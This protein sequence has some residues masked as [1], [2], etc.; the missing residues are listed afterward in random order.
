MHTAYDDV[1]C[2]L[3][4]SNAS[5]TACGER[6]QLSRGSRRRW[7][8]I[9]LFC[10]IQII[11][12]WQSSA[13]LVRVFFFFFALYSSLRTRSLLPFHCVVAVILVL[14]ADA[15]DEWKQL[16]CTNITQIEL[17]FNGMEFNRAL[18]R[19]IRLRLTHFYSAIHV[20][21]ATFARTIKNICIMKCSD[22]IA[23]SMSVTPHRKSMVYINILTNYMQQ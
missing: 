12:V 20:S 8:S 3:S 6:V 23:S 5:S 1:N 19:Q 18:R 2:V 7:F 15:A 9:F 11:D 10:F 22:R 16:I 17:R 21:F 14:I 13:V 4:L